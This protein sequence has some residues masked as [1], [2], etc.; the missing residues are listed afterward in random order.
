VTPGSLGQNT[1]NFGNASVSAGGTDNLSL[2]SSGGNNGLGVAGSGNRMSSNAGEYVRVVFT[3]TAT[4]LGVT[5][6]DFGT[7]GSNAER[8]QLT[9]FNGG[10]AVG[11]PVV[12]SGCRA[13]GGLASY[14][15]DAVLAFDM[16]EV[17]PIAASP[18]GNSSFALSA[19]K[20]C[21]ALAPTCPSSLAG[22][23]NNCP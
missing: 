13:D 23:S 5:L 12:K 11:S 18:A 7:F 17:K 4:K 21:T 6:N 1:I 10:I 8:V 14:E 22:A 20:A 19:F 9:F 15:I 2:D 16:V 3:S